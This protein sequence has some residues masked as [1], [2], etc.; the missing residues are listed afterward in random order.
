MISSALRALLQRVESLCVLTGAG[1][2]AESGVPTFRGAEG[3]WSKFKP[4]ELANFEAFKRNPEL[5][6]EWYNYRKKI[7]RETGPNP[8]H[9]AL[10]RFEELV[11]DF[12]L[13]TQNVDNLHF[14]AG[15]KK[16]LELHGNI[17]RNFCLDCRK[18][19]DNVDVSVDK[20]LPQCS[21]CG[22]LLR[23]AVVWFGEMLPAEIFEQ[24]AEAARRCQ[25]FL[26]IGTSAAV[27]PAA[28]LPLMA[29]QHGA[30]VVEIN[31]EKTDISH[32]VNEILSGKAG[33][34]L[35][36]LVKIIEESKQK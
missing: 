1:I 33:E 7:I 32:L 4:Q 14:R 23:P 34:I 36:E 18:D 29:L 8:A 24:A 13:V 3:L 15:S 35:P 10:V 21:F 27:Y 31:T 19:A 26:T 5:I 20:K 11:T 6:W 16:V 30:Y 28:G 2:S 22:G 9:Y 12:T 25:L 17:E